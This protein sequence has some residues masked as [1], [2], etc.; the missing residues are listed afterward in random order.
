MN[1][2]FEGYTEVM[3]NSAR[4]LFLKAFSKVLFNHLVLY[5]HKVHHLKAPIDFKVNSNG[6][7]AIFGSKIHSLCAEIYKLFAK[8]MHTLTFVLELEWI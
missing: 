1:L 7:S 5:I 4:S 2:Y 8:I 3:E 6:F